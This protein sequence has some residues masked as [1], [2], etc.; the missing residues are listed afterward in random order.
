MN[1]VMYRCF[2]SSLVWAILVAQASAGVMVF[3]NY[4]PG[5]DHNEHS[6]YPVSGP[7][8]SYGLWQQAFDFSPTT[9][10]TLSGIYLTLTLALNHDLDQNTVDV[11]LLA[12]NQGLPGTVLESWHFDDAL[13]LYT[14]PHPR[15]VLF[16]PGDGTVSLAAGE[17]YWVGV[18]TSGNTVVSWF[19]NITGDKGIW[20]RNEGSGWHVISSNYTRPVFRVEVVPEPAT[21]GLLA[22]GGVILSRRRR[23]V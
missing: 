20:C 22:I 8:S 15:P 17:R 1:R 10:D 14:A 9:G 12:D 18:G 13:P 16:C 7:D 11:F 3:D 23:S 2:L 4:A 19:L 21:L 5:W 6:V